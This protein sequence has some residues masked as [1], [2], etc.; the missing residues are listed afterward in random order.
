MY[1]KALEIQGFKS[2]PEKT[3]LQFDKEITAVVGPNGSGKSNISDAICWVMGEQSSRTLRGG[4]ME[5]VIFGGTELRKPLGFAQVSLILD[6]SAHL[7]NVDAAEV[8][9]TRRY[10]RSGESEY[11]INRQAV[12]LKDVNELFMDT[13]LGREGYAIIGQGRIDDILSAKS[14]DRRAIFEEAAGIS[15]FR[16]RKDEAERKLERTQENLTRVNDKIAELEGQVTSLRAQAETA[17][18]YLLLR[19]ELRQIEVS[20]WLET[21]DKLRTQSIKYGADYAAAA[22]ALSGANQ[23]LERLYQETEGISA[24]MREKDMEAE[25][26]QAALSQLESSCGEAES[27][28]A[29]LRTHLQN[30]AESAQRLRRDM[31]EQ[32]SRA[33]G[34]ARQ[35]EEKRQRIAQLSVLQA[36]KDAALAAALEE[37][38]RL[39]AE[40]DV[41]AQK[42]GALLQ[43]AE[44]AAAAAADA[45]AQISALGLAAQEMLDRESGARQERIQLADKLEQV[46]GEAAAQ[47]QALDQAGEQ[48]QSLQNA[49][50]GYTLRLEGRQKRAE[51]LADKKIKLRVEQD[52]L[53]ARV[54]MLTE[55]ERDYEGYNRAV[56]TVMQEAQRGA[57]KGIYGPVANLV[58][59]NDRYALAVETALG[60]A[61]QS[62]VVDTEQAGKNAINLLKRAGAGRATFLPVSVIRES[63]LR[64]QGLETQA[65]FV[66]IA[67]ELV[68]AAPE[69]KKIV[70]NLLG[71]VVVTEDLDRAVQIARNY[72]N[73]F[74][75]VTLDG[76]V[77]HAGGSM[78]GGSASRNTGILSRA[79]E[80]KRLEARGQELQAAIEENAAALAQ[81][82]RERAAD[83]Y[84]AEQTSAE[85]RAAQDA[86]L[87]LS[88][89]QDQRRLLLAAM[90]ENGEN[91]EKEAAGLTGRLETNAQAVA[92]A[93]QALQAQEAQ[94]AALRSQAEQLGGGQTARQAQGRALEEQMAA[95]R[96]ESAA[97]DAEKTATSRVIQELSGLQ[98]AMAGDKDASQRAVDQLQQ[99]NVAV[100]AQIAEKEKEILALNGQMEANK[101]RRG[102]V[103]QEK[104]N[105]EASRSGQDKALQEA[106]RRILDLERDCARLEQK[107]QAAELEEKHI[108]DKLWDSYELSHSAAQQVRIELPEGLARA[109]RRIAELK[110]GI[111]ALGTP[112]IGAIEE[113]ERVNARYSFLTD[114]RDDIDKAR[115]ELEQIIRSITGEMRNIFS[116]EFQNINQMFK[117]TF[118]E[119]FGGGRA[120]LRLEDE[121]DVL[122]SGI[123]IH[124]QPPGK[125]LKTIS[126]LSGGEKVFVAIALYF[127]IL[128]VRPTPF[129]VMDEIEA[130][131]DEV[132]VERYAAYMR[133]LS[134]KTQFI[135]ITHRRGT[136]E[137]A[138]VLYGVTMQEQGVSNV[139]Y[140]DL[141]AAEKQI[142]A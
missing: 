31:E 91:L 60:A 57:L 69:Y 134:G 131:L 113:Y 42:I 11:A 138:D 96:A 13:G 10:Y 79:N 127:A 58:S 139:L 124:V 78:T 16:H 52:A 75:I 118:L 70:W 68:S 141:D 24:Q 110:R 135:V 32:D 47:Q 98:A 111:S 23:D 65:G 104:L 88:A 27:A 117:Q 4:K 25:R 51:S 116:Q 18:K 66:G 12:R 99:Q 19:D 109:N 130:A 142:G 80:L 5:D 34:L 108:I 21:L 132:N 121:A 136:M 46:R 92:A 44:A 119:L 48:A 37:T 50:R 71:R 120:E 90:E 93:Q 112:N 17:K 74:R 61:M 36:E 33:G 49:L 56:K 95:I 129:C 76:Q 103:I 107:K 62:V 43:Q 122:G 40:S 105:L 114:Q 97:L 137:A 81:A 29:V 100:Q 128:K 45:R 126:L 84:L 67:A 106:N 14:V 30:N 102:A 86:V 115:A 89:A 6:N 87:R 133:T 77:I 15:R 59:A 38:A 22:E 83:A 73:R 72:G 140:V 2:F 41:Q 35:I 1:L 94:A 55:M 7:F 63:S 9:V 26:L 101:A 82:E 123:E 39:H 85:L 28:A 20:V 8:V 64:E 125:S 53:Q 54:H 3:Y